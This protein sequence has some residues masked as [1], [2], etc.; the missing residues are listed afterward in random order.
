[1]LGQY[2]QYLNV[3]PIFNAVLQMLIR[4]SVHGGNKCGDECLETDSIMV[5]L[6]VG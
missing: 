5:S 2:C 1:M 6:C 3:I 4:T